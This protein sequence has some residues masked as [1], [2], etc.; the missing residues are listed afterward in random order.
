[1]G[2]DSSVSS[3]LPAPSSKTPGLGGGGALPSP[4]LA[5]GEEEE[6]APQ[7]Q[8]VSVGVPDMA[9]LILVRLRQDGEAHTHLSLNTGL[10][11]MTCG[12]PGTQ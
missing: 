10:Q 9:T 3:L 8:G 2:A 4:R 11:E 7:G 1:M 12:M 5:W 6:G